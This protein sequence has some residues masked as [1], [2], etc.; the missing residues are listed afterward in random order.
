MN[1]T[2]RRLPWVFPLLRWALA[3]PVAVASAAGDA[4][5]PAIRLPAKAE[6]TLAFTDS[7]LGGLAI[8]ADAAARFESSGI[9]KKVNLVFFNALFSNESGY[10]SLPSRDAK[11]RVFGRA[12]DALARTTRP[13]LIVIGCNTLSVIYADTAFAHATRIPVHGIVEPGVELFRR[14]LQRNPSAS[15]VLFGTETTL[16]ENSHRAALLAAGVPASRIVT[17]ACPELAAYIEN[18]WQGDDTEL[19]VASFVDD[20]AAALPNPRPPVLAGLVCSHYG[21]AQEAWQRAFAASGLRLQGLLDP[22]AALVDNLC[23]PRT[24]GRPGRTEVTARVLSMVEIPAGRRQSLGVWLERVSPAVAAALAG[25][26]L[27]PDLFEWR[28]AVAR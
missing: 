24:A 21:Y 12:L 10:N 3:L 17:K 1:R 27:H 7:G 9:A 6:L 19:M 13:D 4:A 14:E 22:N 20:A 8:M 15:L 11:L 23:P 26:E 28:S 18:N 2:T 16:G 5:P 25:Y